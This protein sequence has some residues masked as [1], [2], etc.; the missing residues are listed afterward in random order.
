MDNLGNTDRLQRTEPPEIQLIF[1]REKFR[2]QFKDFYSSIPKGDNLTLYK[3]LYG[4]YSQKIRTIVKVEPAPKSLEE[5]ENKVSDE[6]IQSLE[7]TI[8][9]CFQIGL[10]AVASVLDASASRP[11]IPRDPTKRDETYESAY[12]QLSE[13]KKEKIRKKAKTTTPNPRANAMVMGA[14]I[15]AVKENG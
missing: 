12:N 11:F 14:I 13:D 9:C 1:D 10:N 5:L 4:W 6:D 2:S 3:K 15:D 8:A 7:M